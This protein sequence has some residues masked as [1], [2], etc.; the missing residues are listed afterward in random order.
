VLLVDHD[1]SL[2]LAVC[3]RVYVLDFGAVIAEGTPDQIRANPAVAAAYLGSASAT[4]A[5]PAEA[6]ETA[7]PA[8]TAENE[9]PA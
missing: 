9:V 3:D 4:A 7:E 2:V 1:V 8:G 6:A 5:E